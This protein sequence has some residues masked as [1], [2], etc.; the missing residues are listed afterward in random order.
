[1]DISNQYFFHLLFIFLKHLKRKHER[2]LMN[3]QIRNQLVFGL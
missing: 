3:E 1:M 2:N